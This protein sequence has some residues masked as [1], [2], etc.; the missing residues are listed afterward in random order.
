MTCASDAAAQLTMVIRIRTAVNARKGQ[1]MKRKPKPGTYYMGKKVRPDGRV[2]VMKPT[3]RFALVRLMP[4][5]GWSNY[6]RECLACGHYCHQFT[7][8][9]SGEGGYCPRMLIPR[10][11]RI[12][13]DCAPCECRLCHEWVRLVNSLERMLDLGGMRVSRYSGIM[14]S[15]KPTELTGNNAENGGLPPEGSSVKAGGGFDSHRGR[16][17]Q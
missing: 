9:G 10:I 13:C 2:K 6:E 3:G 5:G 4:D 12:I 7:L 11:G 8:E 14:R 17:S 15:Y 16:P 1:T